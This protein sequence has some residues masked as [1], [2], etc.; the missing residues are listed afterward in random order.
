MAESYYYKT[1][2]KI[3]FKSCQT[4]YNDRNVEM[5]SLRLRFSKDSINI[6]RTS[7]LDF[8]CRAM[9]KLTSCLSSYE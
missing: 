2:I 1:D 6:F 9:A 3:A 8:D 5:S 7:S 4:V